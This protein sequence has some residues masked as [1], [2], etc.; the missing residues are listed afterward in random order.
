[1]S[2]ETTA[3]TALGR[4]LVE[5][6]ALLDFL[7]SGIGR[8]RRLGSPPP[9]EDAGQRAE[10]LTTLWKR[11]SFTCIEPG[12]PAPWE[13]KQSFLEGQARM[14][15]GELL[16]NLY[17]AIGP[18]LDATLKIVT[19]DPKSRLMSTE[20]L[21]IALVDFP[22]GEKQPPAAWA[23]TDLTL[24]PPDHLLRQLVAD[25]WRTGERHNPH[26]LLGPAMLR[27]VRVESPPL[28][29]AP[30]FVDLTDCVRWTA[31]LRAPQRYEEVNGAL[32]EKANRE[33]R[34]RQFAQSEVG[35]LAALETELAA[36]KKKQPA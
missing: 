33:S 9:S 13:A 16:Q 21:T 10:A 36:L 26:A 27:L 24:L 35:R 32:R 5:A 12:K 22:R 17:V 14:L 19:A 1:M 15:P 28:W 23:V 4:W 29:T 30:A 3:D 8:I 18:D 31:E 7:E 11:C 34:E 2:V 6:N 20:G 25:G